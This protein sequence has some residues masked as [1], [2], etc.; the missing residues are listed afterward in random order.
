MVII[1][2]WLDLDY[3]ATIVGCPPN[4][5]CQVR[6]SSGKLQMASVDLEIRRVN[7]NIYQKYVLA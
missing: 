1:Q 2:R 7:K 6:K 4:S 3:S 5:F